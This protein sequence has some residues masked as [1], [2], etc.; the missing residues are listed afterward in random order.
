MELSTN[1]NNSEKELFQSLSQ[2][3]SEILPP[4]KET[5]L[6][7]VWL[8]KKV[9]N[10]SI[11]EEFDEK[12]FY[13][14]FDEV[15]DFLQIE[16]D[17]NVELISQKIS[18]HFYQTGSVGNKHF[19]CLTIYAKNLCRLLIDEIQPELVKLELYHTFKRTLPLQDEDL[20]DI[21]TLKYWYDKHFLPARNEIYK[22]IEQLHNDVSEKI[23][24]LT[25]LLKKNNDN[26][27]EQIESY[28][29]IFEDLAQRVQGIISALDYKD[30]TLRKVKSSKNVFL[31]NRED[32]EKYNHIQEEV[33]LFFNSIDR[34]V[35]SISDKIQL[36]SKRLRNLLDT[37]KHKQQF[38]INIEKLLLFLLQSSKRE[39]KGSKPDFEIIVHEKLRNKCLSFIPTKF[40]SI[41]K[42]DFQVQN[43]IEPQQTKYDKQHEQAERNK[44]LALLEIQESTAKWLDEINQ[45]LLSNEILEYD[46]WFDKIIEKENNLEVPIKVCFGLI[47]EHNNSNDKQI[48]IEKKKISKNNHD[49]SLWKMQIQNINS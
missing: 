24:E 31:T 5:L 3:Y 13:D 44:G 19:M 25:V 46:K 29:R 20:R 12:D 23:S 45:H 10:G 28:G 49:L 26:P 9:E 1:N 2:S 42:L 22:H 14:T 32:F 17:K 37:L 11:A 30:E 35:S 40:V 27:K 7:I 47:D 6:L 43:K 8:Y 34:R 16:K 33:E 21:E 38:K 41:P 4:N 36:A 39:K 15:K 48:T 18:N